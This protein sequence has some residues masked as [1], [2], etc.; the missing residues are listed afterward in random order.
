MAIYDINKAGYRAC[1]SCD[2]TEHHHGDECLKSDLLRETVRRIVARGM[3]TRRPAGGTSSDI[4][5]A[6][7]QFIASQGWAVIDSDGEI[8]EL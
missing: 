3:A 2:V 8:V 7:A 5:E 1:V 4:V 6:M